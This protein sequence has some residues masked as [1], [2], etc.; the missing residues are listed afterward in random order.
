[1]GLRYKLL[2]YKINKPQIY[3]VQGFPGGAS[4]KEPTCHCRRHK[5]PGFYPWVRKIPWRRAWQSTPVF[6]PRES[7]GQKSLV[8]YSPQHRTECNMTE[9][10]QH[11]CTWST[12]PSLSCPQL[13]PFM[14]HLLSARR[15]VMSSITNGK[16]S[17]LPPIQELADTQEGTHSS[18]V[19]WL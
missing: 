4:G 7:H 15:D 12:I 10:T 19:P 1:M 2:M 9:M 11:A 14:G 16:H 18:K 3:I 8:D 13:S 5:R 6:L 17:F